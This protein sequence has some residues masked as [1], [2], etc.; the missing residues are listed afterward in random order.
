MFHINDLTTHVKT[1]EN[2][3]QMTVQRLYNVGV[4]DDAD[5]AE[6]AAANGERP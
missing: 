3:C 4:L 6:Y 2:N 1:P 5:I